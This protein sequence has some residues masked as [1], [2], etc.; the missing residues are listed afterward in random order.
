MNRALILALA[1]AAAGCSKKSEEATTP[2]ENSPVASAP[3]PAELN[4]SIAAAT[5]EA[6]PVDVDALPV[7]EQFEEEAEKD[8]TPQNLVAKLDDIEKEIGSQ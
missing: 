5:P 8:L 7:E 2:V 6:A 4:T 3:T 1:L